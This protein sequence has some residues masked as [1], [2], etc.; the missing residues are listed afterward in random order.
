VLQLSFVERALSAADDEARGLDDD[1]RAAMPQ[2][3]R[4][5]RGRGSRDQA[6]PSQPRVE[7]R[8]AETTQRAVTE[9]YERRLERF[10]DPV[11]L[12]GA[13][14]HEQVD[15]VQCVGQ[16]VDLLDRGK[17]GLERLL[18]APTGHRGTRGSP[19]RLWRYSV[20]TSWISFVI[21]S[22]ASP[23]SITVRGL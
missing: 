12:G 10:A 13:A 1:P 8:G 15:V 16:I 5:P 17:P 22:L 6:R 14:D 11:A 2:E 20:L 23:N 18:Q 21:E 19:V 9:L 4:Q 7:G 3:R